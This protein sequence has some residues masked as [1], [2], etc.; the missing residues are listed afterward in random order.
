MMINMWEDINGGNKMYIGK[1][2]FLD[3][4]RATVEE[5][6]AWREKLDDTGAWRRATGAT[7]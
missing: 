2:G 5:E 1:D 4:Y 3:V 7:E 6:A